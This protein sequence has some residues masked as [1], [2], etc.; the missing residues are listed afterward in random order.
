GKHAP[1]LTD[2]ASLLVTVCVGV[3][4]FIWLPIIGSFSDR[5]GRK[6]LLIAATVLAIDTDYPALSWLVEQ[7]SFSHLLMVEMWL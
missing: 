2:L 4:T 7:P 1:N 6:P 3:S 5:I